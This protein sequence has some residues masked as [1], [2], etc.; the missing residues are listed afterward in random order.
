M[1]AGHLKPVFL[2]LD[3]PPSISDTRRVLGVAE[4]ILWPE[5]RSEWCTVKEGEAG[6]AG[7]SDAA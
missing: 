4:R 3:I 7:Y 2:V 6:I 5:G 1:K